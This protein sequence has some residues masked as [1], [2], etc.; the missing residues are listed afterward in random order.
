M[1]PPKKT[2]PT[3]QGTAPISFQLNVEIHTCGP[4]V[5]ASDIVTKIGIAIIM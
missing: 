2:M 3:L 4:S 5:R 1:R